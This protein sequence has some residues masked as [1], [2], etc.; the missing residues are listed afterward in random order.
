M[1]Q[2]IPP[3]GGSHDQIGRIVGDIVVLEQLHIADPEVVQR[4]H[5]LGDDYAIGAF[6]QDLLDMGVAAFRATDA[7]RELRR[8]QDASE[9]FQSAVAAKVD[10]VVE[11][12]TKELTAFTTPDSGIIAESVQQELAK[13]LERLGEAFDATDKE[14]ILSRIEKVVVDAGKTSAEEAAAKVRRLVDASDDDSPMGKLRNDIVRDLRGPI[15]EA[16]K[17]IVEVGKIIEIDRSVAGE[18]DKGTQKGISFEDAVGTVLSGCALPIGD[19]IER[20]SDELGH[21]GSKIGDYTQNVDIGH[22]A[23]RIV[24]EVK[25]RKS[26]SRTAALKELNAAASNRD[27]AV[28]VMVVSHDLN[29]TNGSPIVKLAAGRYVAVYDKE[30]SDDLATQVIYQMA[31][32][33]AAASIVDATATI[34]SAA[35]ADKVAETYKLLDKFTTI[36]KDLTSADKGIDMARRHIDELK[37]VISERLDE[38]VLMVTSE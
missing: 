16:A 14:S 26:L 36:K 25:D 24:W 21:D 31:R 38:L 37:A 20:T 4:A 12:V 5:E 15:D 32:H 3:T 23:V 9:R 7:D 6:G 27:A 1:L 13:V 28:A 19:V 18:A 11:T 10:E 22:T 30:T 33:E 35:I 17:I 34:D 29:L 2:R 8:V